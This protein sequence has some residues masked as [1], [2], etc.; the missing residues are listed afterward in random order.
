MLL[1]R[2]KKAGDRRLCVAEA[3]IW[4]YQQI[5]QH[6]STWKYETEYLLFY[7]NTHENLLCSNNILI[8]TMRTEQNFF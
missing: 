7:F 5:Q 2:N 1:R 8:N 3:E 4:K 6:F